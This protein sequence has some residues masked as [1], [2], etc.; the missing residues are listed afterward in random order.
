LIIQLI[1]QILNG[2]VLGSIYALVASGLSL[3][4]GSMKMLNFAHGELYML[5]GFA[6]Y[7][8]MTLLGLPWW[9]AIPLA[10][11]LILL[12]G[13]GIE[14]LTIEPL[15][16]RP[17]WDYTP[18]IAT[19]GLSIFLQN[20]ALL[21]FGERFKNLPYFIEGSGTY[22]G[23]RMAYQRLLILVVSV[24]VIVLFAQF[25]RRSKLGMALR[26][27]AQDRDAA[28]LQGIDVRGTY[29]WTF[30]ISGALAALA[31]AMVAP[32]FAINPWMGGTL[33]IKAFVVCVVGGLGDLRGAILGGIL[34][35]TAE[36]LAVVLLSSEWKDVVSFAILIIVLWVRP[37]GFFGTKEW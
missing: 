37:S 20:A 26:A 34:L 1:E 28:T 32:I 36:S 4:W 33:L 16:R 8:A 5:G 7:Y 14:K 30:G 35:G 22:F 17:G 29:M 2:L 19:L 11:A 21:V 18:I 6:T 9:L 13:F 25:L 27:V 15:L 31:S 10:M 23:M 24:A 12:V 3:I